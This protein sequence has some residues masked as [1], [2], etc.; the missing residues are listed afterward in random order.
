MIEKNISEGV[1]TLVVKGNIVAS[2]A[3]SLKEEMLPLLKEEFNEFTIDL[4][5]V[6]SI[7]SSGVGV[8]IAA[9]NDLKK[10]NAQLT[11]INVSEPILKMFRIMR[12]DRHFNV[13]GKKD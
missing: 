2:M 12:L 6:S 1:V 10:K 8:L 7:D 13:H 5:E 9:Q 3:K 4:D 11:V